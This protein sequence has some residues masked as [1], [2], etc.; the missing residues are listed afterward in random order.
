MRRRRALQAEGQ[1]GH[2][3]P[4]VWATASPAPSGLEALVQRHFP[5]SS[6]A[7]NCEWCRASGCSAP[8]DGA[9]PHPPLFRPLS[10]QLPASCV[11]LMT[12]SLAHQHHNTQ[13]PWGIKPVPSNHPLRSGDTP[14]LLASVFPLSLRVLF[15]I[16]ERCLSQLVSEGACRAGLIAGCSLQAARSGGA[17]SAS[18]ALSSRPASV[19]VLR[20]D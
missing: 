18:P 6:L 11:R 13:S 19:S 20:A 3:S 5:S 4:D 16:A 14:S 8:R 12:V 15:M 7:L 2:P 17:S 9:R 1:P 10:F